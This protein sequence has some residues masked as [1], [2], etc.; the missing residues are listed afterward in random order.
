VD[1][2]AIEAL[3]A[4][5]R[6]GVDALLLKGAALARLLYRD[7]E[8]RGYFDVDLLVAPS[9]VRAAGRALTGLG[10]KN[11]G[12]VQGIDDVA[13]ILHAEVWSARVPG[14]GQ[15][16]IDLHWRLDGC[17]APSEVIWNV[18]SA[19]RKFVELDGNQVATLDQPGLALHL[20]LHVAQHGPDDLKAMGDLERGTERW[21]RATWEQAAELAYEL[22]ATEAFSAG[23]RLLPDG[24]T[25]ARELGLPSADALLWAIAHRSARP[26]GTYHLNALARAGT[27]RERID[28]LRRSLLPRRAWIAWEYRWAEDRPARLLA[29]YT[30]HI[31]RAPVWA[32]R[33]WRFHRG[34]R[35]QAP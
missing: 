28:V 4:L 15:L 24:A 32:V 13:G 6:T 35:R 1:A 9:Q 29:A 7:D 10:Y 25:L 30:I 34:A 14:F 19:R 22:D 8:A 17:E 23:L 18:L 3:E 21:P 33:A 12:E 16:L 2:A 5:G 31:A 11:I 27:V 26:R 20:A